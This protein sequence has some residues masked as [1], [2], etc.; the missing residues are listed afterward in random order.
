M[1]K[2]DKEIKIRA[3]K[4]GEILE[5]PTDQECKDNNWPIGIPIKLEEIDN[6]YKT[7]FN[8]LINNVQ[9]RIPDN[10]PSK[11]I[12]NDITNSLKDILDNVIEL[13]QKFAI[14][15]NNDLV[16]HFIQGQKVGKNE[17]LEMIA[18]LFKD[19]KDQSIKV[20]LNDTVELIK[21]AGKDVKEIQEDV[22]S[23]LVRVFGKIK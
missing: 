20:F 16:L 14:F 4:D 5:S 2:D 17:V 19:S 23:I 7:K 15:V 11:E 6:N 22:N 10:I 9:N 21:E 13:G 18:N 1:S 8:E 12:E 3:L